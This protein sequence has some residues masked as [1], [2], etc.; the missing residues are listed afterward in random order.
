MTN[1]YTNDYGFS[2]DEATLDL[3]FPGAF[4]TA[5]DGTVTVNPDI[6]D[7]GEEAVGHRLWIQTPRLPNKRTKSGL[8]LSTDDSISQMEA[9]TAWGVVRQ[10][11]FDCY[12]DD[13]MTVGTFGRPYCAV[14]QIVRIPRHAEIVRK[15]TKNGIYICVDDLR[16]ISVVHDW[17]ALLVK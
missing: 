10:L 12:K 14:G 1:I 17:K 11:G 6:T 9:L 16:V 15:E 7:I 2:Q 4:I 13:V 5:E 3:V 8:I